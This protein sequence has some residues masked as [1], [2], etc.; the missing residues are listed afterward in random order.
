MPSIY[1]EYDI[2]TIFAWLTD[3]SIH[4]EVEWRTVVLILKDIFVSV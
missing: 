4:I 1:I 3:I 2:T